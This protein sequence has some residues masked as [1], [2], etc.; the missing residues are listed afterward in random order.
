MKPS[1]STRV[2]RTPDSPRPGDA[3]RA[4]RRDLEA[5]IRDLILAF[6]SANGVSISS[7]ELLYLESPANG[8]SIHRDVVVRVTLET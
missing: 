8:S 6:N 3:I 2:T 7:A 5:R 4:A 1:T